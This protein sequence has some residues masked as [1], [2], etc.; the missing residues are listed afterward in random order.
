MA[1]SCALTHGAQSHGSCTQWAEPGT[2][3]MLHWAPQTGPWEVTLLQGPLR[4]PSQEHKE[5]WSEIG[6]ETRL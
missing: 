6:M 4:E 2:G 3:N 1:V 5:I